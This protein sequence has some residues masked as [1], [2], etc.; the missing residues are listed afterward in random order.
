MIPLKVNIF[1]FC[2]IP[3][4]PDCLL[5]FW[6][7][8]DNMLENGFILSQKYQETITKIRIYFLDNFLSHTT[9]LSI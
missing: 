4:G 2:G 8:I 1:M 6:F 9:M 3:P 7:I 5:Q